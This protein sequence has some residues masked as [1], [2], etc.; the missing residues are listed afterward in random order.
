MFK[1]KIIKPKLNIADTIP[2]D[3]INKAGIISLGN[4][5]YSKSYRLSDVNYLIARENEQVDIYDS[6]CKFINSFDI[7]ANYN[8]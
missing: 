4:D 6:W 2:F 5:R 1:N 8:S 7:S 3:S